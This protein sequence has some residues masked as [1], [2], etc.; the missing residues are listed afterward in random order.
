MNMLKWGFYLLMPVWMMACAAG[1]PAPEGPEPVMAAF[2]QIRKGNTWYQKGCYGRALQHYFSAHEQFTAADWVPGVAMCMNNIGNVY[3]ATGDWQSA[4][5]FFG[6]AEDLYKSIHRTEGWLQAMT[7]R[8]A[9]LTED[10]RFEDAARLLDQAEAAAGTH[11]LSPV[12]ALIN[13]GILFTR[14]ERYAEAEKVLLEARRQVAETDHARLANVSFALG[15]VMAATRRY[16]RALAR[17]ETAL[18]NDRHRQYFKGMA[19]DLQALGNVSHV[20]GHREK[21]V[22]YAKR[23]VKMYALMGDRPAAAEVMRQLEAWV[24]G[25]GERLRITRHFFKVWTAD[26]AAVS[27]CEQ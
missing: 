1:P 25:A 19:D 17:F 13:R 15:R 2:K 24:D 14:Q 21:A 9:A 10:G 26:P 16:P 23:A 22:S 12:P 7:N 8:A 11:H 27:P 4:A 6:E 5:D 20:L 18:E 3:R